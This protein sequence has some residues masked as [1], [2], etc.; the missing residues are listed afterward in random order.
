MVATHTEVKQIMNILD[1]Y[2]PHTTVELMLNDI[3]KRVGNHTNNQ[4]LRSTIL[5][6]IKYVKMVHK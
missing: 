6:M 5:R 2:L 1:E 4:S 3:W